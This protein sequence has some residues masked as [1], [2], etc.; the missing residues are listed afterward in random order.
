LLSG[1]PPADD[2]VR[3]FLTADGS[4]VDA[5]DR[6]C[7]FLEVLFE[8]TAATIREEFGD[9]DDAELP[10]RFRT[11]MTEGQTFQ[12]PN[13]FR[14]AFYHEVIQSANKKFVAAQVIYRLIFCDLA[15]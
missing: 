11:R 9:T 7:A 14:K 10:S 8:H 5:Y 13:S 3:N 6:V 4:Q 2:E 15:G 12:K 1:F